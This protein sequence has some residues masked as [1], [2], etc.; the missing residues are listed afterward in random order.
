MGHP[1]PG[2]GDEVATERANLSARPSL[3]EFSKTRLGSR[4]QLCFFEIIRGPQALLAFL[5]LSRRYIDWMSF[6][7]AI[8]QLSSFLGESRVSFPIL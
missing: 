8:V 2:A 5:S 3:S 7:A 4:N 1:A 6:L